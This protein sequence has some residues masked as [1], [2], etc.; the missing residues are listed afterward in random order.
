[1]Q[2]FNVAAASGKKIHGEERWDQQEKCLPA[3]GEMGHP[4]KAEMVNNEEK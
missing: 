3:P 1:M 2:V 4:Y